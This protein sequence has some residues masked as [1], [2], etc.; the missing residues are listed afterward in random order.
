M[1]VTGE[2]PMQAM[3]G[4]Y[5]SQIGAYRILTRLGGLS[6]AWADRMGEQF[7]V[8]FARVGDIGISGDAVVFYGGTCWHGAADAGLIVV[9]MPSIAW[10][11][12][13]E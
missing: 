1:A 7:D 6:Q 2:D 8:A 4:A 9:P 13:D 11:C 3:R 10:R 12:A 5:E